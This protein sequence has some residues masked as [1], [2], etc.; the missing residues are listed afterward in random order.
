MHVIFIQPS[1]CH[2]PASIALV[3]IWFIFGC[4]L[5]VRFSTSFQRQV[6]NQISMLQFW[7][8]FSVVSTSGFQPNFSIAI[9]TL[10][11]L[12]QCQNFN[13]IST[14]F[15]GW[16]DIVSTL[17]QCCFEVGMTFFNVETMLFWGWND[18]VSTLNQHCYQ[19]RMML[20]QNWYNIGIWLKSW[21]CSNIRISTSKRSLE[22]TAS[23]KS[24]F[25]QF[26]EF[27]PTCGVLSRRIIYH[28]LRNL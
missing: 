11:Q 2:F 8:C 28:I 19:F 3:A 4:F 15:S 1:T 13:L 6:F 21:R 12:K 23:S 25:L 14:L 20:F 22:D 16:N 9:Q 10:F 5:V 26:A 27:L 24:F 18:V 17:D 7:R